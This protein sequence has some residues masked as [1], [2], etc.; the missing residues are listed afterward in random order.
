[1][2]Q[3]A[4]TKI[5]PVSPPSGL[6]DAMSEA[7]WHPEELGHQPCQEHTEPLIDERH[8]EQRTYQ[9]EKVRADIETR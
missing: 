3:L 2:Q 1:M 9:R 7:M 5:C 8:E 6:E 4:L